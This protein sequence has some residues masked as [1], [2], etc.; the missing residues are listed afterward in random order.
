MRA[1][2]HS[3]AWWACSPYCRRALAYGA[4][5]CAA[6]LLAAWAARMR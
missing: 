5:Q 3:R 6:Q 4:S 2:G 1:E